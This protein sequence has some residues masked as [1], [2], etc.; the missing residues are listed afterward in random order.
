[1][2]LNQNNVNKDN[3]KK[4]EVKIN[5]TQKKPLQ[6]NVKSTTEGWFSEEAKESMDLISFI[7]S[8]MK[9]FIDTNEKNPLESKIYND[10]ISEWKKNPEY[11]SKKFVHVDS[12]ILSTPVIRDLDN[13][14]NDDLIISGI[15]FK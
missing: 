14:G 12:H 1:M 2:N 3:E 8:S 7:P 4:E 5:Q 13:D 9:S 10:L 6:S 11:L 15:L